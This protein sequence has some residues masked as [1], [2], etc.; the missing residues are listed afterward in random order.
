MNADTN[1]ILKVYLGA[2][3]SGGYQPHG[4]EQRMRDAYHD[5]A[6][7]KLSLV[8][9]YLLADHP[10]AEWTQNDLASEQSAFETI[11]SRRFPELD[12]VSINALACRW[13]YGWR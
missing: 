7:A 9:K 3:E 6:D 1:E 2:G 8:Q 12:P 11:L 10:V 5:Q 13:S 4:Y